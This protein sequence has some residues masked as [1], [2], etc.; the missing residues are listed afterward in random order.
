M[1]NNTSV[2]DSAFCKFRND[3]Y[4]PV[5]VHRS[6]TSETCSVLRSTQCSSENKTRTP[7]HLEPNGHFLSQEDAIGGEALDRDYAAPK[8]L[9]VYT[10]NIA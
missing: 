8:R 3:V 4:I 7:V 9:F 1:H 2:N 5:Y 10:R 6:N